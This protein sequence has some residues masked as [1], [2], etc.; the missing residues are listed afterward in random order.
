MAKCVVMCDG[1]CDCVW[2]GCEAMCNGVS[3][4]MCVAIFDGVCNNV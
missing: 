3:V 4:Q 1:G 2:C